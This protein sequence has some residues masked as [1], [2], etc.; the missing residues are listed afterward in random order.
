MRRIT[1]GDVARS[2][3]VSEATVSKVLNGRRGVGGDTRERVQDVVR[4]LGYVSISER[5]GSLRRVGEATIEV[6]LEPH[7]VDNPYFST[8]IGGAVQ[9]AADSAAALLVRPVTSI[10]ERFD[11]RWAQSVA[12]AGRVGVIELTSAY[13]A[14]RE[15]ALRAVGLP[16]VLV[17]PID[18]PRPSTPSIGAT[19]WAGAYEA[20][21]HL[22]S[23]GHR[24][25]D[26]IGGPPKARCDEVRAHG[27]AAAMGDAG[28]AVDIEAVPR[29]AY[30]FEHGLRAATALLQRP[31]PPTA[32]FA[33]SD[34]SAKGVLEAARRLGVLVPRDLSVVG[35]DDTYLAQTSTP[36]LTTVHQPIADIGRT[37]V[38]TLLRLAAGDALAT[39]RIELATHLVI[40]DSTAPPSPR[41]PNEGRP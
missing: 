39:R 4:E 17:D 3:N 19:N 36:P 22:L 13:S 34:I 7:D 41:N 31:D 28:I 18:R 26:Y 9:Q 21:Q 30:S 38:S 32:I 15:N 12:R 10:D 5:Q 1:I 24:R 8:F 16:M 35:F 37:A 27:W 40:R 2:A 6:L 14:H 29:E 11:L 33:G 25:I 20:A 23:L